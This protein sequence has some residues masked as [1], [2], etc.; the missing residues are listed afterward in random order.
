MTLEETKIFV[1]GVIKNAFSN[2]KTLDKFDDTSG[3]LKYNGIPISTISAT[4]DSPIGNIISYMGNTV[5]KD[6]LACDGAEYNISDYP[7]LAQHV[8]SEFG[9]YNY[10]GG[11]GINTFAVPDLRGEFLRGTGVATRNIG[12]GG[13]V[14]EHQDPTLMSYM[15]VA[16]DGDVCTYQPNLG[17]GVAKDA[18]YILYGDGNQNGYRSNASS[19]T[20][21]IAIEK[22]S[23][24]PTNTSV[25]YCIKY[26]VTPKDKIDYSLE[27]Q[28]VGKWI[29][30]KPLYQKT[31]TSSMPQVVSEKEFVDVTI[32]MSGLSIDTFLESTGFILAETGAS[33]PL[34]MPMVNLGIMYMCSV[35][36]SGGNLILRCNNQAWNNRTAYIT[37][38][39]TK[40]TDVI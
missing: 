38:R 21:D 36:Y 39:Y 4:D 37:I 8:L 34:N 18:D 22:Y 5:P 23:L 2:K 14:G 11:D 40:S 15:F 35:M 31:I 3:I 13:E 7:L 30:G 25:L 17:Q 12:T 28:V 24:R 6:Y 33:I 32:N 10:F 16:A 29:N 19:Y 1:A 27:E 9:S 26:Q 20:T